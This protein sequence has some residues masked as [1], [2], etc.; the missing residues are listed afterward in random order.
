LIGLYFVFESK[1]DG[2]IVKLPA[3]VELN[4]KTGQLVTIVDESPEAPFSAVRMHFPGGPNA[5]LI[6]PPRCGIYEIQAELSSWA[7]GDPDNPTP[8]EIVTDVTPFEVTSGP[9]GGPCPRGAL[10]PKMDAGTSNPVAGEHSP[11]VM[12]L[13]RDDGSQRFSA[14]SLTPPPGLVADLRGIPYCSDEALGSI[15]G[16][17]MTGQAQIDNPS[18]PAA[19]LVGTAKAGAGAGPSPFYVET[20]RAYLAGPYKGAPLSLALVTPAVA[21]PLDL[22]NVVVRTALYVNPKTARITAV[23]DPIPTI[24]HGIL[25]DVRDI[26][27]AIDRPNFTLNPTNCEPMSVDARIGGE[28]GGSA[29]VSDRFQVAGCKALGFKPRV[30]LSLKGGTKRGDHPSLRAVVRPRPGDANIKRAAVALPSSAFLDQANIRTI[31]T[32]VQWAADACPKAAR[33]GFATAWSPLLDQPLKG[34]A[35]L[36][37]SDNL[38][39]DLVVD[40]RGPEHLPLKIEA[41]FRTDSLRGGIRSTLDIAPDA[42]VS[43]FVLRMH[44]GKSKGLIVNSQNLCAKANRANSRMNAHNGRRSNTRPVVRALGCKKAKGKRGSKAKRGSLNEGRTR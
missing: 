29:E 17:P 13:H 21:G 32:R 22:G 16:D 20:G 2:I 43:R 9:N 11:F 14:L 37:S 31:C 36:R 10:E 33:Y 24:L 27:V 5:T 34:P 41:A 40:L 1:K 8:S 12:R 15:S 28:Q 23:S 18:C 30:A 4:P 38:L 25:V 19:S 7:A 44:G 42:P 26:R 39:P 35:Y 6:T 3:R